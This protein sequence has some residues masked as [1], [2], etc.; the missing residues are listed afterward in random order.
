MAE[1]YGYR[2]ISTGVAT[3]GAVSDGTVE[4]PST[5]WSKLRAGLVDVLVQQKAKWILGYSRERTSGAASR[6]HG[7]YGASRRE[8]TLEP[9]SSF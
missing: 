3:L 8:L 5:W 2:S 7:L 1:T 6:R 9:R 4:T